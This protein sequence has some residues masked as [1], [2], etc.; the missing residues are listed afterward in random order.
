MPASHGIGGRIAVTLLSESPTAPI[1]RRTR[2]T[3]HLLA[4]LSFT[5]QGLPATATS[6]FLSQYSAT[7]GVGTAPEV[8]SPVLFPLAP[9]AFLYIYSS[10]STSILEAGLSG[11]LMFATPLR[12][13]HAHLC[14]CSIPES[15]S[16]PHY[17][18]Y[19]AGTFE[20]YRPPQ[21]VADGVSTGSILRRIFQAER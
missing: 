19:C 7:F 4:G 20:T 2:R 11:L 16:K 6:L 5:S 17:E 12:A 18:L 14:K 13:S 8:V 9:F 3:W 15:R 10:A 1:A 21:L